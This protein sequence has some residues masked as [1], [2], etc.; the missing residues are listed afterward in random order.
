MMLELP[1]KIFYDL[2]RDEDADSVNLSWS[3]ISDPEYVKIKEDLIRFF[4]KNI[5]E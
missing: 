1:D 2:Q 4:T 5:T 3:M